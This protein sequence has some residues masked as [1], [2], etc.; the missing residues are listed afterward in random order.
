MLLHFHGSRFETENE[1]VDMFYLMQTWEK[2][3]GGSA[4]EMVDP[5]L[6]NQFHGSDL[7][8]CM[9]IGLLCVQENPFARPSMS[10]VAVMLS[11]ATV[12]LQAPSQPAFC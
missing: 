4:L 1:L 8:R 2:W 6:G 11:S 3:R 5:A 10:T 12:T 7:L 9:Q